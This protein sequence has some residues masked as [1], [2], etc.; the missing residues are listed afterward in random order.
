GLDPQ[1]R[2]G[3]RLGRRHLRPGDRAESLPATGFSESPIDGLLPPRLVVE[4]HRPWD[5]DRAAPP[6]V[7]ARDHPSGREARAGN[8][9]RRAFQ[10]CHLEV[11][12]AGK[13]TGLTHYTTRRESP[14]DARRPAARSA[15]LPSRLRLDS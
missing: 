15:P 8:L 6:E 5:G 7:V 10:G 13:E 1:A 2:L 14:E 4:R 9:L 12:P 11:Q 3:G